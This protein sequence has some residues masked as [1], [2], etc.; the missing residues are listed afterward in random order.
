LLHKLNASLWELRARYTHVVH[1][2]RNQR[3]AK[4]AKPELHQ[5]RKNVWIVDTLEGVI[6]FVDPEFKLGD[7]VPISR[8]AKDAF[9][10]GSTESED[11]VGQEGQDNGN[12]LLRVR[13]LL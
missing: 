13:P 6:A 11:T 4:L 8:D 12:L 7:P 2:L 9:G 10:F 1:L 3:I 5:R